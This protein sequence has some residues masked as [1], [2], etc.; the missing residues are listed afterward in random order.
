MQDQTIY[1][2]ILK[3]AVKKCAKFPGPAESDPTHRFPDVCRDFLPHS[4]HIFLC[5]FEQASKQ[6]IGD[7]EVAIQ[8]F[9]RTPES[10]SRVSP[11]CG[12][13][14]HITNKVI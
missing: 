14:I 11:N 5:I 7:H 8:A 9:N 3:M 10:V 13:A 1:Q 6:Q 4:T 12:D 2:N